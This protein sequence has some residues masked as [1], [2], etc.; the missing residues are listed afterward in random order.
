M[1]RTGVLDAMP[2]YTL[3]MNP[4]SYRMSHPK[5]DL[6]EIEKLKYYHHEP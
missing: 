4:K 1:D 6:A 2:K 5:F 3:V